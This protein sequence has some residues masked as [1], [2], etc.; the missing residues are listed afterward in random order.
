L[1]AAYASILDYS[2]FSWTRDRLWISPMMWD[3]KE[4]YAFNGFTLAFAMNV[5]LAKVTAPSGYSQEAINTAGGGRLA[6]VVVP[7]VEPDII[8]VMSESFWDPTRLPGVT[9][10]FRSDRKYASGAIGQCVLARI[11]RHD[12]Q[13]RVRSAVGLF[14]RLF[15]VW[16]D[17]VSAICPRPGAIAAVVPEESG[18]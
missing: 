18:L 15:A 12:S 9:F 6:Q 3:Q 5:P 11:R 13:C 1:I 10:T 17:P 2:T 16:F 7:E 4:N 14:Q 8:M